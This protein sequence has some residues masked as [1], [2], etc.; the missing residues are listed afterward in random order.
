MK[1]GNRIRFLGTERMIYDN[2]GED[3]YGDLTVGEV[4]EA[5]DCGILFVQVLGKLRLKE[6]FRKMNTK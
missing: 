1:K 6:Y 5:E 4:Y 3:I 2:D